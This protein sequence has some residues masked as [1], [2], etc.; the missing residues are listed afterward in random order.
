MVAF[1]HPI[2]TRFEPETAHNIAASALKMGLGPT[3]SIPK[4]PRL[5]TKL[6]SLSFDHPVG[7]A[8]GFDKQATLMSGMQKLG[9]AY[10]EVGTVTPEPQDGH[11]RPRIFRAREN[12]SLINKMGFPSVGLD[13]F[14]DNLSRYRATY[15]A[16][17]RVPIAAN[18]GK[19][20]DTPIEE[21]VDDY[22][23][24]MEVVA[25]LS[26]LVVVNI[27]S[28]NT[29]GLRSLQESEALKSLLDKLCL[30]RQKA[31]K[32]TNRPHYQ[33]PLL[34]KLSPD[35]DDEALYSTLG[36]CVLGGVDG[37]IMGNT[38]TDRPANLPEDLKEREGG[39]SGHLLKG[40]ALDRLRKA[41]QITSGRIPLIGTGG[42]ENGQDVIQRIQAGAS[43]VQIYTALIYR[44]PKLI[45]R[46]I[47][48]LLLHMDMHNIASIDDMVGLDHR[49]D[50]GVSLEKNKAKNKD[51]QQEQARKAS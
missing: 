6:W 36:S 40:K 41:Y 33:P 11:P 23:A 28:P 15:D 29:Q 2:L 51:D 46:I 20:M 45:Q 38:T 16:A 12:Q 47:N 37:V 42:I 25:P 10:L 18:I 5:V 4:D 48:E 43:L 34:V 44:G 7:L 13:G 22:V 1:L 50:K 49:A 24:C 35:L 3:V 30:T 39:L 19:N 9:F 21:A 31:M 14:R 8:A 27:S 32:Q 26:D 17:S